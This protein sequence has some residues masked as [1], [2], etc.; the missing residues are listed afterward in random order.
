MFD[1]KV[2][3]LDHPLLQHTL[4][5]SREDHTGVKQCREIVCE[6]S[7]LGCYEATRVDTV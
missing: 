7:A 2:H 1:E 4:S 3:V 5:I 6:L